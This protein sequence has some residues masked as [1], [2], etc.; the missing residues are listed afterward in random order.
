MPPAERP[1]HIL[2]T[3]II[4]NEFYE[5]KTSKPKGIQIFK[6]K[7]SIPLS[8]TQQHAWLE[9]YSHCAGSAEGVISVV[10][11]G[12]EGRSSEGHVGGEACTLDA[13]M[14]FL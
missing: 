1:G 12:A 7:T 5:L 6:P 11:V 13:K 4:G 10:C 8:S 3:T 9:V 14:T 2:Y